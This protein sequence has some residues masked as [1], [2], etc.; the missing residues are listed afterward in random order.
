MAA[1]AKHICARN[2]AQHVL[3]IMNGVCANGGTLAV[4]KEMVL[5]L[6]PVRARTRLGQMKLIYLD[7]APMPLAL[8]YM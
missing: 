5:K 8:V 2:K 4:T 7:P 1:Q 6:V 3:T